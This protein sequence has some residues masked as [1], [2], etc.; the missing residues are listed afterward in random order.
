MH[1]HEPGGATPHSVESPF[2][3]YYI[4]V[5]YPGPAEQSRNIIYVMPYSIGIRDNSPQP[6]LKHKLCLMILVES[7]GIHPKPYRMFSNG[8][9]CKFVYICLYSIIYMDKMRTNADNGEVE[10]IPLNNET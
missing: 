1:L 10:W 5:E 9:Q 2:M 4:P 8:I 7:S 3:L 6:I